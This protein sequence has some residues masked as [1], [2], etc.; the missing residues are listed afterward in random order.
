MKMIDFYK[1]I[2]NAGAMVA[3]A[4]GMVSAMVASTSI[5]ISVGE[6]RLVIPLRQHVANPDKSHIVLFHPLT[7]N[8]LRGESDVMSKFRTNINLKLNMVIKEIIAQLVALSGSNRELKPEHVDLLS[9]IKDADEK[10]L[11]N[12]GALFAAMPMG[13]VEKCMLHIFIKKNAVIAGKTH[14]RGAIV[15]FPLYEEL[16]TAKNSVYG[17]NMRKKDVA[18]LKAILEGIFPGLDEKDRYSR[19]SYSDSC[20]TL[21][22]LLNAVLGLGSCINAVV[23]NFEAELTNVSNMRYD[24]DWVEALPNL[25]QFDGEV[26]ML[27]M[28][29]GNEGEVAGGQAPAGS[30]APNQAPP[31]LETPK[32]GLAQWD[33]NPGR[34]QHYGGMREP[35][36][37]PT[38]Y[39]DPNAPPRE[40]RTNTGLIDYAAT[41]RNNPNLAPRQNRGWGNDSGWGGRPQER[42]RVPSW[43]R[44]SYGDSGYGW[45]G[46]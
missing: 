37:Q 45:G 9:V 14:R 15:S 12:Y 22:A 26:R 2:L 11:E 27:P 35:Q 28:Q 19:A 23:E 18:N 33:P 10:M 6:K 5:P 4:D 8:I 25:S 30:P 1:S 41:L 42:Q 21:D 24:G 13:D 40:V 46:R 36:Y 34:S 16:K 39:Q 38:Q 7:E 32:P 31:V 43:E 29:A 20:P 44:N 17:V 3:D